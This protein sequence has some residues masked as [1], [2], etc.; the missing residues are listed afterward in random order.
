MTIYLA[1]EHPVKNGSQAIPRGGLNI[2]ESFYYVRNNRY[3]PKLYPYFEN[4]MLDSGAFTFMQDSKITLDWMKYTED[5]ADFINKYDVQLFFELDID[6]IVGLEKVEILRNRLEQLTGKKPIPVWHE[7]R[8]KAYWLD[9]CKNYPYVAIGGLA[10]SK[11]NKK[12]KLESYLPYF[13]ETA[14]KNNAKIHGL[15]YTS[16]EKL[17]Q[18]HFDSVDSKAWLHGNI[19]GMAIVMKGTH[20]CKTMRGVKSNGQMT[21]AYLSGVFKTDADARKEFYKLIDMNR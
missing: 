5:Y 14:H 11:G 4:F 2:L 19:E 12:K 6:K 3:F 18:L 9:M 13:I 7:T 15:G 17:K 21:T 8:N 1:G 16:I 10:L 20:L